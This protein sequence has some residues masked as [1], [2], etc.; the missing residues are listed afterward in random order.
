MRTSCSTL[1]ILQTTRSVMPTALATISGTVTSPHP[2]RLPLQPS[3]SSSHAICRSGTSPGTESASSVQRFIRG[4]PRAFAFSNADSHRSE[5][6]SPTSDGDAQYT[7]PEHN[8][9]IN[10]ENPELVATFG[11]SRVAA[12]TPVNDAAAMKSK[13]RFCSC[14]RSLCLKVRCPRIKVFFLLL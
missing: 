11:Q 13:L 6:G 12:G 7:L 2:S 5:S 4:M 14:R 10:E 8:L 1:A 3:F 9:V